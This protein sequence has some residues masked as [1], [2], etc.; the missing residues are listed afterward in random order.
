MVKLTPREKE[1]MIVEIQDEIIRELNDM[2]H[3]FIAPNYRMEYEGFCDELKGLFDLPDK[4]LLF[5]YE[6]WVVG[7]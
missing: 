1:L 4:E 7:V 2:I 3:E 5:A 6:K